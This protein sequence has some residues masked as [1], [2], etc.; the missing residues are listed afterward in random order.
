MCIFI[1]QVSPSLAL[2]VLIQTKLL[3][4][5]KDKS[6]KNKSEDYTAKVSKSSQRIQAKP[7]YDIDSLSTTTVRLT[8]YAKGLSKDDRICTLSNFLETKQSDVVYVKKLV[9]HESDDKVKKIKSIRRSNP[10][11]K[12]IFSRFFIL[13][14]CVSSN[15][16]F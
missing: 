13:L 10:S 2:I 5:I 7:A 4:Y 11:G 3:S 9:I 12:P 15:I 16:I 1:T 6:F 8:D 14:T